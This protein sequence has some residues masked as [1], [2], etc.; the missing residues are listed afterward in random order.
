MTPDGAEQAVGQDR[1]EEGLRGLAD[2]DRDEQRVDEPLG[3]A[4][5]AAASAGPSLVPLA[6]AMAWAL[7]LRDPVERRLGDGEEGE[8]EQQDDD[9]DE[10]PQVGAGEARRRSLRLLLAEAGRRGPVPVELLE[11]VDLPRSHPGHLV[12]VGVVVAEDVEHAVHD[13]QRQ[14]VVD[15]AGVARAPGATATAGQITTSPSRS[16]QV[17]GIGRRA[18]GA[19]ALRAGPVVDLDGS[20]R[21]GRRARRSGRA[22]RGTPR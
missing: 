20:R 2:G 5:P 11:Q 3:V 7:T 4:R 10:H 13:E 8:D 19:A 16:G 6:S 18:V 15:G 12:R 22:C 14:L 21:S 1:G 9:G 17:A